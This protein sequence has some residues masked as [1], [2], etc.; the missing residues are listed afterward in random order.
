MVVRVCIWRID[1]KQPR[2]WPRLPFQN[3]N[4]KSRDFVYFSSFAEPQAFFLYFFNIIS[5]VRGR[6]DIYGGGFGLEAGFGLAARLGVRLDG[7]N[8]KLKCLWIGEEPPNQSVFKIR[9][10]L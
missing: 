3:S 7:A 1:L 2:S 9:A 10:R 4:P 8:E 5:C 6:G